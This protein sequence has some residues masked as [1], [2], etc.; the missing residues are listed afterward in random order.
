MTNAM[1]N[2]EPLDLTGTPESWHCVDC[3]FNT[4]PGMLNMAELEQAIKVEK[5]AGREPH[6]PHYIDN[7]SE[8]YYVRAAVWKRAGME[9]M[10]GCLCI[11]CLEKR[12]GRRLKP[13][14]FKRDHV[15]NHPR[16]PGTI[17]LLNRQ[18]RGRVS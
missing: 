15:F 17:R 9:P 4:A 16:I 14:D 6:I 7:R 2:D 5:A 11:G 3:D 18:K 10:G 8:V 1:T 13:K 12:I